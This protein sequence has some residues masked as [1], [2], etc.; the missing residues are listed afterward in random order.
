MSSSPD[1][2]RSNKDGVGAEKKLPAKGIYVARAGATVYIRV[3]GVGNL[4][5]APALFD[6]AERQRAEGYREF[7]FDLAECRGFDS[8]FMGTIV[9]IAAGLRA[10]A[11]CKHDAPPYEV[12]S[13]AGRSGPSADAPS[14]GAAQGIA[15]ASASGDSRAG[16]GDGINGSSVPPKVTSADVGALNASGGAPGIAPEPRPG[17]VALVN[18]NQECLEMLQILG[19]DR[20]VLLG[21]KADLSGLEMARLPDGYLSHEERVRLIMKAHESLVEID[22]RNEAR[23]GAF[24]RQLASE[25]GKR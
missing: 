20:F 15:A 13:D 21:G 7:V 22:R 1:G 10:D 8:S 12:R 18:L 25:L 19:A 16:G 24:L 14:I 23:F 17:F 3:V 6:F 4:A 9:G 11:C 5:S 2:G